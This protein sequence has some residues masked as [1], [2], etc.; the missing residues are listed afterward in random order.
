MLQCSLGPKTQL[1]SAPDPEN[2]TSMLLS[3]R[4]YWNEYFEVSA[5]GKKGALV[6]YNPE[7]NFFAGFT[8]NDGTVDFFGRISS[9]LASHMVVLDLG[10]GRASWIDEDSCAYRKSLRMIKGRVFKVIAADVDPI[11]F[12]NKGADECVLIENNRIPLADASVDVIIADYVLEHIDS[13]APFVAEAQ[14]VLKSGGYFCARTPH[15]WSYISIFAKLVGNNADISILKHVQPER[16]EVDV[17]PKFYKLNTLSELK[18]AFSGFELNAFIYRFE[19]AYFFGRM[20]I[21]KAQEIL[22]RLLP[23]P[24]VGNVFMFARKQ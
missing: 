13:V 6:S 5:C 18:H 15:R 14:R 8:P 2:S 12:K 20:W 16:N 3:F 9:I 19:P 24:I 22:H 23:A 7:K 1:L 10:A 11:V 21:Y 17:F 4:E